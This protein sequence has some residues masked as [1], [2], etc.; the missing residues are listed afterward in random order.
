M[1]KKTDNDKTKKQLNTDKTGKNLKIT[2]GRPVNEAFLNKFFKVF[3]TEDIYHFEALYIELQ[4]KIK[5]I[6]INV[7]QFMAQ[8][9][10]S[11]TRYQAYKNLD[12]FLPMDKKALKYVEKFIR[13]SINKTYLAVKD[14]VNKNK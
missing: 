8:I 4:D 6:G 3:S 2:G 12:P 14:E 10:D 5:A 9:K 7:E 1:F 11:Y 13:E